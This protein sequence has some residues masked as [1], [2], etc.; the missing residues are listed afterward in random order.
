MGIQKGR[1][2][3]R[4]Y[5][6]EIVVLFLQLCAFY[7]LPL[8][9]GPTDSMGLVFLILLITMALSLLLGSFSRSKWKY[10]YP[11]VISVL[12]IPSVFIHYNSSAMIHTVW[13]LVVCTACLLFGVLINQVI[14]LLR[15]HK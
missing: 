14:W 1:G 6:F 12:F 2:I 7:I 4:R 9:A 8:F 15:K 13:Y 5:I 11:V 3:V 10:A